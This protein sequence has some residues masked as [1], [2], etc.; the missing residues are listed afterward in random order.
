MDKNL[1][2]VTECS[3]DNV[4]F[5]RN[6]NAASTMPRFNELLALCN[7]HSMKVCDTLLLNTDSY[8][9]LNQ[10]SVSKSW[11]VHCLMKEALLES[12]ASCN[13]DDNFSMSGHCTLSLEIKLS[14]LPSLYNEAGASGS[15]K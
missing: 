5:L 15:F 1:S 2:I 3:E 8:T 14:F 4:C 12:V 11:L 13:T 10:G 9:H 7:D 6:F